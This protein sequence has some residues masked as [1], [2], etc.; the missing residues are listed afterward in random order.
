[1]AL[2][3]P[4]PAVDGQVF[5][6]NGVVYVYSST[7]SS[8]V[9]SPAANTIV[10]LVSGTAGQIYSSG[11][12]A[13]SLNLIT[14]A[15]TAATYGGSSQI[16][17]I[18]VD[19][20]G[21]LTSASN[22]AAAG[23]G[24]SMDYPYANTIGAASNGWANTVV[25]GAN[26]WTNTVFGYANTRMQSIVAANAV[27]AN[28]W[29]NTKVSSVTG[30]AGQIYVSTGTSPV[31]NLITTGVTATTYG[32]ATIIPVLTVD[33]Y[34]R[35]TAVSNT[36][37]SG[38]GGYYNGNNGEKGASNYGDIFR[39]HSNTLT[40]NV[41]IYTGNNAIAAGPLYVAL[42]QTLTIQCSA[43]SVIV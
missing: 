25:A 27:S 37:S 40:T 3:F 12:Y 10:T 1:M 20:Y 22:V 7:Y 32:N 13:P 14:T 8:W 35:I 18:T 5:T 16:P 33:A 19:A 23:G 34:G 4:Y 30:T 28:A 41:T 9:I 29:A 43:R 26:A 21:R 31:I 6:S 42:G 39:V 17:V 11:G 2:N 36:T 38:G 15:V 24:G